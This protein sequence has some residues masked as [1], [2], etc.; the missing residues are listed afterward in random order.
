MESPLKSERA[1]LSMQLSEEKEK[2][3]EEEDD[4]ERLGI[5]NSRITKVRL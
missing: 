5:Y 2:E 3:E 4:E 1:L